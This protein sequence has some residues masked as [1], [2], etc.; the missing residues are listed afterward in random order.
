MKKLLIVVLMILVIG[1]C[2]KLWVQPETGETYTPEE[3]VVLPAEEQQVLVETTVVPEKVA[4]TIDAVVNIG[5]K[6][7]PIA[8]A[9]ASTFWPIAAPIFEGIGILLLGIGGTWLKL[10]RPLT[11]AQGEAKQFYGVTAA[12]VESIKQWRLERPEDWKYLEEKLSNAIG[13]KAE[14]VIRALRG[15]PPKD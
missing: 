11:E 3:K 5:D 6:T 14:N 2:T 4:T 9:G 7:I 15:L 13:D 1:G 8:V 12:L 10:R